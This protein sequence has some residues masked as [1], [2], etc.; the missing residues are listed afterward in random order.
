MCCFWV[1]EW[2]SHT[3]LKCQSIS[4]LDSLARAVT[5]RLANTK[6]NW[7]PSGVFFFFFLFLLSSA[8]ISHC[9][10]GHHTFKS[11]RKLA[12]K[13]LKIWVTDLWNRRAIQH[14]AFY[15]VSD[16]KKKKKK[17]I[18]IVNKESIKV[19][20]TSQ[21]ILLCYSDPRISYHRVMLTVFSF[22]VQWLHLSCLTQSQGSLTDLS[23]VGDKKG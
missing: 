17:S 18:F 13:C 19:K 15:T 1:W 8:F 21:L 3:K 12:K 5:P 22:H 6:I 23:H 4:S 7:Y 11:V 14:Q 2:V 20:A 16:L 9:F 10:S